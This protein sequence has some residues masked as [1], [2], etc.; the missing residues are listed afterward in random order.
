[1]DLIGAFQ[2]PFMQKALIAGLALGIVL[3]F[4]GIFVTLRKMSFFG[5]G[6]AHASLAGVAFG[7]AVG[8]DPFLSALGAGVIVGAAVY[9]LERKTVIAPDALIG[10]L[11]TAAFALGLVILSF[12]RGYQ[13]DLISFLF[14]NIL[15]IGANDLGIIVL[16]SAIIFIILVALRRALTLLALDRESAWLSGMRTELLDFTFYLIL[17]VTIVLGIKLLGII[18]V[19][20]LLLIPPSTAKL[21]APSLRGMILGSMAAGILAVIAGLAVS[22]RLDLPAGAVIVL[23]AAVLFFAAI[24]VRS[25]VK[26]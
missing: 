14:G 9:L 8:G 6:I 24:A 23:C 20:A 22:Y 1:M 18:L 12:Q 2:L 10:V 4:L 16:F 15:T 19:G 21:L 25:F 7:L 11:F 26:R 13:P 17:S 3:P 5:E